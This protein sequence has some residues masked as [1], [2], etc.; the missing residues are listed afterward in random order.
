M[1]PKIRIRAIS[2]YPISIYLVGK[3][4]EKKL[5]LRNEIIEIE[6]LQAGKYI[7]KVVGEYDGPRYP[8]LSPIQVIK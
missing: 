8:I 5:K 1:I 2:I 3:N 6:N 7:I 4:F